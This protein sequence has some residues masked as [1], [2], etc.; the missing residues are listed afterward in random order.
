M[1]LIPW[2]TTRSVGSLFLDRQFIIVMIETAGRD[3]GTA[4]F[5]AHS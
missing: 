3:L 2:H 5:Y 1:S 4:S